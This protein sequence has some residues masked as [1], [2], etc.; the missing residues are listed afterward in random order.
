MFQAGASVGGYE[1]MNSKQNMGDIVLLWC[2][3]ANWIQLITV[4][5]LGFWI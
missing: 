4:L 3:M 5:H 2:G 1:G